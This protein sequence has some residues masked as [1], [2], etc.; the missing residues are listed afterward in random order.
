MTDIKL[1]SLD[2]KQRKLLQI[3][4]VL[5]LC[6]FLATYFFLNRQTP[7]ESVSEGAYLEGSE[8]HIFEDKYE[9][10]GYPDKIL[11]HYPYFIYI[12][13]DKPITHIYNLETKEKLSEKQDVLLDYYDGNFLYN[14]KTTFY[15]DKDLGEFCDF[16]FIKSETEILCITKK[17]Q[18]YA[19]N[20]LISINPETPNLWKQ[21]YQSENVLT[22]VS[23]INDTLYIGEINMDTKQNYLTVGENTIEV[24]TPVSLIYKMGGEPYFASF[25]SALNESLKSFQ[26]EEDSRITLIEN[27]RINF[28]DL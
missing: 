9:F 27:D 12:Q 23:I 4:V 10:N 25:R 28:T 1:N 21:V 19:D 24:S 16:G 7:N 17:S 3:G 6:L 2:S 8:L 26:I 20:M 14:R 13:G 22:S 18:N 11:S 5:M 15:N